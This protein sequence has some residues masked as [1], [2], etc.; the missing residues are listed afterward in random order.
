MASWPSVLPEELPH[1]LR[2]ALGKLADALVSLDVPAP[3]LKGLGDP[4]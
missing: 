3:W 4:F 1:R 2:Q